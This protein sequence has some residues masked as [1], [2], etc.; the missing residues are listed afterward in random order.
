MRVY[1]RHTDRPYPHA[2]SSEARE[3]ETIPQSLRSSGSAGMFRLPRSF[4]WFRCSED[5]GGD[6]F[7]KSGS[8]L[9]DTKQ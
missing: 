9:A 7:A 3:Q 5:G 2:P 6:A 1:V 4:P 8:E